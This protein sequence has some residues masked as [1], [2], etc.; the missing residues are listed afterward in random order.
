M[1]CHIYHQYTFSIKKYSVKKSGKVRL[2]EALR[3]I[4]EEKKY[5]I[6]R[7]DKMIYPV[8]IS[9]C[10]NSCQSLLIRVAENVR[11][12]TFCDI[13][14]SNIYVSPCK[15]SFIFHVKGRKEEWKRDISVYISLSLKS[16]DKAGTPRRT[17]SETGLEHDMYNQ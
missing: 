13:F 12:H 5:C 14:K 9:N 3:K 15:T 6:R 17:N 2:G 4:P 1:Q 16:V 11:S 7:K 10:N 8:D